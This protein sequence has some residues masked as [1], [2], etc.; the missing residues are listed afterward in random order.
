M[1]E[2]DA[3]HVLASAVTEEEWSQVPSEIGKKLEVFVNEKI[4]ELLTAKALSETKKYEAETTLTE[5]Q[6]KHKTVEGALEESQTKLEAASRTIVELEA[7]ISTCTTDMTKLQTTCNRL[8]AEAADFRHQRNLAFGE[9][10]ELAKTLERT[11][12]EVERLQMDVSTLTKQ[13]QSAVNAKC[14]ALAE[15]NEVGSLKLTLEYKEK[16]L[17]Q[18][19]ALLNNHVETLTQ[20]LHERTEELLNM[21]KDNTLRCVQLENKLM[22]KTQELTVALESIKN[23]TD[24]NDNLTT[25]VE[26]LTD[27]L[28]AERDNDA[29]THELF[30][31][32]L[33]AQTKLADLY[34]N[35]SDQNKEQAE[36]L[37]KVV[38]DLQTLLQEATEKYGDLETKY[39]ETTLANEE[40]IN[41]KNECINMLKQELEASNEMFKALKD[42]GVQKEVEELSPSAAAASRLIKP[43]MSLT[44]IYTQYV[45][46]SEELA[47]EKEECRRLNSYIQHIINEIE[48]KGPL[49]RKQR[50]DYE[51]ALETIKEISQQNDNLL[52][53]NQNLKEET[54]QC[55]RNEGVA[56]RENARLKKEVADLGRQVCHLLREV[57]QSRTGSSSTS[58]DQDMSDS[59]SSADIITKRLVTFSDITELQNTNQRLLALVRELT[60]KQEEA[61][62]YDPAAIASL[63]MKL[64]TM[65]E[66]QS[67]LLEQ[68][69]TQNKMMGMVISQR[70]MYKTLYEQ[71]MKGSGEEIPMQ[72]ERPYIQGERGSQ[73]PKQ[74]HDDSDSHSDD[75]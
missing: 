38:V 21:K 60:A 70:D 1:E 33:E 23:L 26:E 59:M 25:K 45:N 14:E 30:Q 64:E 52:M 16:R 62:S 71:A 50:E 39:K 19:R 57:E 44:Q 58:T 22:E 73:S 15:A 12:A 40:I 72:L 9:R 47:H 43:G 17:D 7:Q 74:N 46:V 55:K 66:T 53:E 24:I 2:T 18:E 13:L 11:S 54:M 3:Q 42:E 51:T 29:K 37:E 32:E 68:Q 49:L 8:E 10:D 35:V 41:K 27:K 63:K 69:E 61:E 28:K 75:K 65:K 5:L 6:D 34:K 20:S 56:S 48:D 67:S 36:K 4:E 31:Q